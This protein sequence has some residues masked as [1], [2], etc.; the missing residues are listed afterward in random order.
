[1]SS[2]LVLT[3][4]LLGLFC[5]LWLFRGNNRTG[6]NSPYDSSSKLSQLEKS[7]RDRTIEAQKNRRNGLKK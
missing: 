5:L 6:K 7:A 3:V 2:L 1:M 4:V